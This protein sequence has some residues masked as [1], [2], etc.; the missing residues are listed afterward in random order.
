[1]VVVPIA[2]TFLG[3][4]L[5]VAQLLRKKGVPVEVEVMRR[6]TSKTLEDAD[7]KGIDFAV[8]VGEKE[9]KEDAVAVRD[10]H[11]REQKTVKI[12]NLVETVQ[13]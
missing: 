5:R 3:D 7:R 9:L 1:V 10:L 4:A 6:K 8:I 11:K 2:P 12:E 13:Q